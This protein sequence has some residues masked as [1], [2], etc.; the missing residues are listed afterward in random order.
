MAPLTGVTRQ[1]SRNYVDW[2]SGGNKNAVP[3]T[4]RRDKPNYRRGRLAILFLAPI[5]AHK[6]R[7]LEHRLPPAEVSATCKY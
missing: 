2:Y 7:C 6:L 1:R 4:V 3:L 5:G